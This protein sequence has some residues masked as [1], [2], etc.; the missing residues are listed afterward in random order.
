MT[1]DDARALIDAAVDGEL[2][3]AHVLALEQHT[4]GCADCAG[5]LTRRRE[6]A[7]RVRAEAPYFRAP[8][9]LTRR[10]ASSG[11]TAPPERVPAQRSA[12][13]RWRAFA[14]AA[15]I[16]A[17]GA[18]TL[19]AWLVAQRGSG[20][21]MLQD[22]VVSGHVRAQLGEHLTDVA[23]SDHHTVKPWLSSHLG[24]S[25]T[26]PDLTDR[27]FPLVGG[28]L[29]YIGGHRAA[30]LVYMRRAHVI[31]A[32]VWPTSD[33]DAPRRES[34]DPRGYRVIRW[35]GSHQAVWVVS[36]V[37]AADLEAFATLLSERMAAQ[38]QE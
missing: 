14:L 15:S 3:A 17:G 1:C 30:A 22:Q 26:V 4:A 9:G 28:R 13:A 11:A 35:T 7:A 25:P 12:V 20:D 16:V 6:L 36:D 33:S 21:Q 37:A 34:V 8:D 24:F 27:G 38:R 2:D 31:D 18:L 23:S 29:E 19:T 32:F 10:F 5:A